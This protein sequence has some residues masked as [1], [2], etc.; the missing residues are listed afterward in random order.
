MVS[1]MMRTCGACSRIWRA[2]SSPFMPGMAMSRS[3]MSGR[4][5][6][7]WWIVSSPVPASPTT[8][9]S[10]IDSSSTR[11]PERTIAWSSATRMRIGSIS[12]PVH[13][14]F[15]EDGRAVAG[16]R[17]DGQNATDERCPLLH[18][19]QAQFLRRRPGTSHLLYIEALSIVFH[20]EDSMAVP[21]VQ[22]HA[23]AP[24]AG[25]SHYVRQRLL[26]YAVEGRLSLRPETGILQASGVEVRVQG[27][28]AAVIG[29]IALKRRHQTQVVQRAGPKLKG[30]VA[31]EVQRLRCQPAQVC[32]LR[33][34]GRRHTRVLQVLEPEKYGGQRLAGL[35]MELTRDPLAL[36]LLGGDNLG[37]QLA[38]LFLFR[39]QLLGH[40]VERYRHLSHLI[41]ARIGHSLRQLPAAPPP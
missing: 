9:M 24:G 6:A 40:G 14:Y 37:Q 16:P 33:F 25:V 36:L 23:H 13:G 21:L 34:V 20:D 28:L 27:V 2:A 11:S 22:Q 12:R 30:H 5:L 38:S 32:R 8:S 26:G 7:T 41:P 35:V 29:D 10:G 19:Q 31:H 18:A 15:H 4:R 3:R 1:T 17:L 39:H